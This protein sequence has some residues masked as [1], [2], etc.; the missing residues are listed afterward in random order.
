MWRELMNPEGRSGKPPSRGK[1][2]PCVYRQYNN[3]AISEGIFSRL[4]IVGL[5][6]NSIKVALVLYSFMLL[7]RSSNPSA[8]LLPCAIDG[9]EGQ[10][11]E[12]I[13]KPK[14]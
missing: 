2:I 11:S 12:R 8:F 7:T 14:C 1:K 10:R 9:L 3:P 6:I 4:S 13:Q 5:V